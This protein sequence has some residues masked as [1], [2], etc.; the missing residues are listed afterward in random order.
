MLFV[1]KFRVYCQHCVTK[2]PKHYYSVHL[3]IQALAKLK[4]TA[5]IPN[6]IK[7]CPNFFHCKK[8]DVAVHEYANRTS[9]H[10]TVLEHR[11]SLCKHPS[12][13]SYMLMSEVKAEVVP[14]L[15]VGFTL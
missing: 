2:P 8:G 11:F 6:L 3:L 12:P 7:L 10:D 15:Q 14:C 13:H 9:T 5:S 4:S 1:K